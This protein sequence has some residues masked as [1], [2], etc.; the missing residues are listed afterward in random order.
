MIPLSPSKI[1]GIWEALRVFDFEAT[2]G[3]F[4]GQDV[5]GPDVKKRVLESMQI[6]IRSSGHP[7]DALLSGMAK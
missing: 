4:T 2:Y 6:Q 3:G 1:H 7:N 5:R